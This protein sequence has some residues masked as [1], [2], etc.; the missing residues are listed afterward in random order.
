MSP[1]PFWGEKKGG[2][3]RDI[4]RLSKRQSETPF[5]ETLNN[6]RIAKEMMMMMMNIGPSL[7]LG[8]ADDLS[9]RGEM[10][11]TDDS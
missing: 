7:S 8:L 2:P 4:A 10:V 6:A 5:S 3:R 11:C 9:E 1:R